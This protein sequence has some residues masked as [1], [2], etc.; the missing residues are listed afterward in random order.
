MIVVR[1]GGVGSEVV[2]VDGIPG[3]LRGPGSR[4]GYD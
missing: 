1:D 3:L 4:E 2:D